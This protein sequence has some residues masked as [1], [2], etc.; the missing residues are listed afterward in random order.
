MFTTMFFWSML[1]LSRPVMVEKGT[2]APVWVCTPPPG[3]VC[4]G[5]REPPERYGWRR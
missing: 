4:G 5:R 2:P 1:G 3:K